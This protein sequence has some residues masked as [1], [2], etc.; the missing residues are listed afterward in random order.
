MIKGLNLAVQW[1]VKELTIFTDSKTVAAW[2]QSVLGNVS[3]VRVS[4]LQQVLVQR[5]LQIITDLVAVTGLT[6]K[7][8]SISSQQNKADQLTRVPSS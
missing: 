6:F 7:V 4:G 2:L 1:Q 3:R 8:Q 5:R